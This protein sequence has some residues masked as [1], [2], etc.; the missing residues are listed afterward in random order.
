MRLRNIFAMF[1]AVVAALLMV[2]SPAGADAPKFHTAGSSVNGSGALAVSFDERGL[3]NAN[4]DYVLRADATAT[5]ACING[6]GNHPQA[7]NKETFNAGVSGG[8]S[9]EPKNGR[10]TASLSAGPIPAGSF[11]CPNG[12]RLVLAGVSYSNVVLTDTTNG[13][14]TSVAGVSRTFFNV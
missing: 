12:Q 7:A 11:S 4:I 9:F 14:S 8:G 6:G 3:G 2:T 10:V 5:Y 1:A 13:V